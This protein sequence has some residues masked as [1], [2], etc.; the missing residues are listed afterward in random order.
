MIRVDWYQKRVLEKPIEGLEVTHKVE[1]WAVIPVG[2]AERFGKKKKK[3]L[4]DQRREVNF[5][6]N[7]EFF[8]QK[9]GFA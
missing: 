2:Q 6:Q 3:S 8:L 1:G 7:H 5:K 9:V 4:L